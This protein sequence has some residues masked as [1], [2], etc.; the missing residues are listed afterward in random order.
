MDYFSL[1]IPLNQSIDF[2]EIKLLLTESDDLKPFITESKHSEKA[3]FFYWALDSLEG[4]QITLNLEKNSEFLRNIQEQVCKDSDLASSLKKFSPGFVLG[5]LEFKIRSIEANIENYDEYQHLI[6]KLESWQKLGFTDDKFEKHYEETM[7]G[8]QEIKDWQMM[9]TEEYFQVVFQLIN[10]SRY[11]RSPV[12]ILKFL[13]KRCKKDITVFY[14]LSGLLRTNPPFNI[15]V[16]KLCSDRNVSFVELKVKL[17]DVLHLL[18]Q[19]TEDE[20]VKDYIDLFLSK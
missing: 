13:R 8:I 5:L 20:K 1:G 11:K 18:R 16:S 3:L 15:K 10:S 6:S 17:S 2:P 12:K 7:R 14:L 19:E 9:K 4:K